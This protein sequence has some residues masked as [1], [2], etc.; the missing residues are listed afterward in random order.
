MNKEKVTELCENIEM[1][2]SKVLAQMEITGIR[3]DTKVLD[4][5]GN[6]M[7]EKIEELSKEIYK[8]S[9]TEFNISSPKQLG[10]VL[11]E[12]MNIP[13]PKRKK[14]DSYSTDEATLLTVTLDV[15]FA[16][17]W[18]LSPNT[19]TS[20]VYSPASKL[21]TVTTPLLIVGITTVWLTIEATAINLLSYTT[22]PVPDSP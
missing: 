11:F 15:A 10:N 2:L 20:K 14:G 6:D 7:K 17:L 13:Y 4:K 5:M 3:C 22:L 9:N 1:P 19:V 21:E 16:E 18:L 12:T 8:M